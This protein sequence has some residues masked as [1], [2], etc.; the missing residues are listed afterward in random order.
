MAGDVARADDICMEAFPVS[1]NSQAG[2]FESLVC[3]RC[4]QAV[5]GDWNHCITCG[6][7]RRPDAKRQDWLTLTIAVASFA[8]AV[9]G[10]GVAVIGALIIFESN[11]EEAVIAS[12][13]ITIGSG[14]SVCVFLWFLKDRPFAIS[15]CLLSAAGPSALALSIGGY[16]WLFG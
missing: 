7:A 16:F 5:E 8:S 11:T 2:T 12:V 10:I 9:I 6:S 3:G 15:T 13:G 1:R 4:K 14:A